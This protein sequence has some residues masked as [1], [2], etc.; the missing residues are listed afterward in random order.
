MRFRIKN[1]TCNFAS[2]NENKDTESPEDFFKMKQV[3]LVAVVLGGFFLPNHPEITRQVSMDHRSSVSGFYYTGVLHISRKEQIIFTQT[4]NSTVPPNAL[5]QELFN[6]RLQIGK[7]ESVYSASVILQIGILKHKNQAP[8]P[9]ENKH[10]ILPACAHR[11][12]A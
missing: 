6:T 7:P 12:A 10:T 5:S 1:F 9:N 4:V 11:I 2:S 8:K 3:V